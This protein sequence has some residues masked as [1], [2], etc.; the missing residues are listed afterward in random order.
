MSTESLGKCHKKLVI[1]LTGDTAVVATVSNTELLELVF[2]KTGISV[3]RT[4]R[5]NI[6]QVYKIPL[7]L[8]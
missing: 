3:I 6:K 1:A 2:H 7:R 5:D 8:N 4:S